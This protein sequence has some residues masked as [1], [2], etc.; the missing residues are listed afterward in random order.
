MNALLFGSIGT[1]ADTSLLQLEGFNTAFREAGLDWHWNVEAYRRMLRQP[2]GKA[3]IRCYAEAYGMPDI[4]EDQVEALHRRKTEFFNESIAD[5]RAR[6]RPGVVR[7]IQEARG[8]GQRV[9]VGL[10]TSTERETISN[11]LVM[12]EGL[13]GADDFDVIIDRSQV[14]DGK[15]APDAYELALERLAVRADA[16]LAIEDTPSCAGAARDAGIACLAT[17]NSFHQGDD[18]GSAIAVVTCLGDIDDEGVLLS[19]SPVLSHGLVTLKNLVDLV[20]QHTGDQVGQQSAD[21]ADGQAD[22][23]AER[24]VDKQ[25]GEHAVD[26]AKASTVRAG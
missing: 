2:G 19:G 12:S 16:C 23:Q 25:A 4:S 10:V 1:L 20:G 9:R 15:P 8:A 7:L 14:D 6:F 22:G 18:F 3:R 21:Q 5:G 24:Q 11:L 13:V 26:Q 17:P